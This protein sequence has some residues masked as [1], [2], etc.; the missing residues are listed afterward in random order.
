MERKRL[1]R[2]ITY[3]NYIT[4]IVSLNVTYSAIGVRNQKHFFFLMLIVENFIKLKN[5]QDKRECKRLRADLGF[6]I[7]AMEFPLTNFI[8]ISPLCLFVKKPFRVW[9]LLVWA[10]VQ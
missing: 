8:D 9:T 5:R 7:A 2:H 6:Q 3:V 10:S 1:N 4:L